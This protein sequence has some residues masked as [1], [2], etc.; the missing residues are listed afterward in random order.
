MPL[1]DAG[2]FPVGPTA[3]HTFFWTIDLDVMVEKLRFSGLTT[4]E[5]VL[6]DVKIMKKIVKTSTM[7][8]NN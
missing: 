5:T 8:K 3:V 4:L 1:G 6:L 2:S 7:I